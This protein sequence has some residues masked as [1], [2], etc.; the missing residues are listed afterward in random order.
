VPPGRTRSF[1][2]AGELAICRRRRGRATRPLAFFVRLLA[3]EPFG[4][5]RGSCARSPGRVEALP[6]RLAACAD[7]GGRRR[8]QRTI[9]VRGTC[10]IGWSADGE[11]ASP[12][13]VGV[14][15]GCSLAGVLPRAAAAVDGPVAVVATR[16]GPRGGCSP[17]RRGASAAVHRPVTRLGVPPDAS[18]SGGSSAILNASS[19]S[20]RVG[21]GSCCGSVR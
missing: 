1:H 21:F 10:R 3:S 9:G 2:S 13:G 14:C 4:A 16:S 6:T 19:V 11:V 20:Q 17:D 15:G 12:V 7:P 8:S 5:S 18:A